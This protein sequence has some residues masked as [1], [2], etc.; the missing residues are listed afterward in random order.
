M[1]KHV[2]V[3]L[4]VPT[5]RLITKEQPTLI[6]LHP[7]LHRHPRE[8][9]RHAGSPLAA[10]MHAVQLGV[11]SAVRCPACP[12]QPSPAPARKDLLRLA[13]IL[14]LQRHDCCHS[15]PDAMR[16]PVDFL[17][18]SLRVGQTSGPVET[19]QRSAGITSSVPHTSAP[20]FGNLAAR[21]P[22]VACV[23]RRE[24]PASMWVFRR[25]M[26]QKTGIRHHVACTRTAPRQ[27]SA[28]FLG[29]SDPGAAAAT[30]RPQLLFSPPPVQQKVK[31]LSRDMKTA[32]PMPAHLGEVMA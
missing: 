20:L 28:A 4:S 30:R 18:T 19:V 29:P 12:Q 13:P 23:N 16:L 14:R 15:V 31:E 27:R 5:S 3:G 24:A 10:H 25:C 7:G 26:C 2:L 9:G 17:V 22:Y 8:P 6:R 32:E 1:D 11:G 21:G